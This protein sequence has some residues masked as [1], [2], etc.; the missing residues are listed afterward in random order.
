MLVL[1]MQ[2][3]ISPANSARMLDAS[4]L[5]ADAPRLCFSMGHLPLGMYEGIPQVSCCL[6][7][8][9][10]HAVQIVVA[11]LGELVSVVPDLGKYFVLHANQ[12]P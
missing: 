8:F 10:N 6:P 4:G 3:R 5:F 1:E 7:E 11:P 9:L 2:R 12:A